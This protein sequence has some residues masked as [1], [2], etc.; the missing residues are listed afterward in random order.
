MAI[1]GDLV[2]ERA[3]STTYEPLPLSSTELSILSRAVDPSNSTDPTSLARQ[4]LTLIPDAPPLTLIIRLMLCLKPSNDDWDLPEFPYIFA[5]LDDELADLDLDKAFLYSARP[6]RDDLASETLQRFAEK[7]ADLIGPK[8]RS[9]KST[10][11]T[12]CLRFW[13]LGQQPGIPCGRDLMPRRP[14]APRNGP[15]SCGLF[16]S[17]PHD[18]NFRN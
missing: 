16:Y 2:A 13:L 11:L 5:N 17:F 1:Y 9:W 14:T 15:P 7:V 10:S 18:F 3:I 4:L 8:V 12:W 6:V